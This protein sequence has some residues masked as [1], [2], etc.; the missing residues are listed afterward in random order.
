MTERTDSPPQ[1][2]ATRR[3]TDSVRQ[4][5]STRSAKLRFATQSR[6]LTATYVNIFVVLQSVGNGLAVQYFHCQLAH[7]SQPLHIYQALLVK[8]R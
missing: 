7:A 3:A 2:T 5:K 4:E 1:R 6:R 8:S